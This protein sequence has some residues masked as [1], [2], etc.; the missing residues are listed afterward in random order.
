MFIIYFLVY[1]FT[2]IEIGFE[3]TNYTVLESNT[4]ISVCCE[5]LHTNLTL[6]RPLEIFV[7]VLSN[8]TTA[9]GRLL[10]VQFPHALSL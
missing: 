3:R 1:F 7:L 6:G 9:T 10:Y 5:I 8:H 2:V 4:S